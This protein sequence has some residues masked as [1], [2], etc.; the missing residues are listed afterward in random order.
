MTLNTNPDAHTEARTSRR[1]LGVAPNLIQHL[2]RSQA[3]TFEKALLENV[4]N[5]IDA[6]ATHIEVTISQ[7]GF[8]V[9]DN[10]VG[11]QTAEEI[12]E[13]FET[14]GFDHAQDARQSRRVYGQF[15]I[16]RGQQWNWASTLYRS[17]TFQMAVDIRRNGLDY[18][19]Q[20]HLT[21]HPGT[22]ITG[23]FY[24]PITTSD[25]Y[26]HANELKT[27]VA[28]SPVDVYINGEKANKDRSAVTWT[29]EDD[30][31]LYL[32]NDNVSL[33]LYNAGMYV[34][35][36]PAYVHGAGGVIVT[37]GTIEVNMA[38]N[39]PSTQDPK[40]QRITR[41]IAR[42]TGARRAKREKLSRTDLQALALRLRDR[43]YE[44]DDADALAKAPLIT[45]LN[46]RGV[47]LERF[48]NKVRPHIMMYDESSRY[49]NAFVHNQGLA[50][51]LDRRTL[52]LFNVDSLQ[53][54]VDI[55]KAYARSK[56][57]T[58][59]Q[60]RMGIENTTIIE[61]V[62]EIAHNFSDHVEII[63]DKDYSHAE[64]AYVQAALDTRGATTFAAQHAAGQRMEWQP[65]RVVI[66]RSEASPYVKISET[67]VGVDRAVVRAATRN[68][69]EL[70]KSVLKAA[71]I[72]QGVNDEHPEAD[73]IH[74][75][76]MQKLPH[77]TLTIR[78]VSSFTKTMLRSGGRPA[79]EFQR[80]LSQFEQVEN[81]SADEPS[82]EEKELFGLSSDENSET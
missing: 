79:K 22:V 40:W 61:R 29:H 32:L 80:I 71:L 69:D 25:M 34:T 26:R 81:T 54:L 11:F 43:H 13:N 78:V 28:Y 31:A 68:P 7:T 38:R 8:S 39:D 50:T 62:T 48:L 21:D 41:T 18:E 60:R 55:L 45:D 75:R 37:K 51:V 65:T 52:E 36:I 16:G 10:G 6:T 56:Y 3:G 74:G 17:R 5:S 42:L 64:K 57:S 58:Y 77:A 47:T 67:I 27:L 66:T 30:D 24:T 53:E 19:L 15:G 82:A 76:F 9:S 73:E 23:T 63:E 2:I 70:Y 44:A 46:G 72:N 49:G 33:R 35:A 14:F 1:R 20:E 59:D 4:M 12:Q